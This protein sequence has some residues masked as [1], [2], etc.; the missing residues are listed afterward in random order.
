MYNKSN[1]LSKWYKKIRID[2][3]SKGSVLVDYFVELTDLS[4][5]LNT[6]EIKRMFHDALR[7]DVPLTV[8]P[9]DGGV[10]DETDDDDEMM[11]VEEN[12]AVK[13]SSSAT[14]P[15]PP[16]S[17]ARLGQFVLDPIGTDFIGISFYLKTK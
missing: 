9:L 15:S 5:D 3:F 16:K 7:I 11:S 17:S 6:L 8:I 14:S 1:N 13:P 4:Q 12:G 10:D 2:S